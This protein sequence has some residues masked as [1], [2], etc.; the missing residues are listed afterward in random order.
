[1]RCRTTVV[2][3]SVLLFAAV[4]G[5]VTF[6]ET[7]DAKAATN[8]LQTMF[9]TG[10]AEGFIPS[11]T[12]FWTITLTSTNSDAVKAKETSDQKSTELAQSLRVAGVP[13]PNIMVGT[14]R[15]QGPDTGQGHGFTVTRTVTVRQTDL[16]KFSQVLEVLN[17]SGRLKFS[18][19]IG[20]SKRAEVTRDTITKAAQ[21]AKNKAEAMA[22]VFGARIRLQS[23]S[24]YPPPGW[25]TPDDR[26]PVDI[27]APGFGPDG[28]DV[29]IT[30]YVTFAIE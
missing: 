4:G 23:V 29:S 13:T 28:E 9:V 25:A 6:A 21:A 14:V 26:V 3:G 1:M 20:S 10:R 12:I 24:E 5:D 22:G 2:M 16:S 11:D 19:V 27:T 8:Q 17:T 30:L 15:M 7:G 18:Y